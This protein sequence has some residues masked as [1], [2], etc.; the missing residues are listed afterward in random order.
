MASS[1]SGVFFVPIE[2]EGNT[3]ALN[4]AIIEGLKGLPVILLD[5][6]I[7]SFPERSGFDLIGID[8]RRA[9]YVVANHMLREHKVH[10]IAFVRRKDSASTVDARVVGFEEA[11]RDA[12][13]KVESRVFTGE[14]SRVEFVGSLLDE[15]K[16]EAIVCA[17]DSLARTLV[18]TMDNT[19]R[20]LK[21]RVMLAG[22]DDL[23]FAESLGL[24]TI[25]QP[26]RDIGAAA[27]AAMIER[28]ASPNMPARDILLNFEL[29]KRES[30]CDAQPAIAES[31]LSPEGDQ[32]N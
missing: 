23:W 32:S 6:C 21:S 20:R 28:L 4:Q 27:A 30:C 15:F 1:V 17:N 31:G 16:A 7:Y 14:P 18:E 22:F 10:R 2:F 5:R 19:E 11:V 12:T 8:N 26:F 3:A 25:C 29:R 9:G 24:T 13:Y